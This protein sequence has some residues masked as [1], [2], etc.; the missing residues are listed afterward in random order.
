MDIGEAITILFKIKED[1]LEKSDDYSDDGINVANN[2]KFELEEK[3][4]KI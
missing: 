2:K 3:L 1:L 4:D